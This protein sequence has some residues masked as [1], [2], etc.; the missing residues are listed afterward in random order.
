MNECK[1]KD[2]T[3]DTRPKSPFCSGTCKK[4]YQRASGTDVPV[5]VGQEPS[6]TQFA[7]PVVLDRPITQAD[8]NVAAEIFKENSPDTILARQPDT[9]LLPPGVAKPTGQRTLGAADMTSPVLSRRISSYQ[10]ADW[11]A[12][13]E[14]AEVVYRLLTL[15]LDQLADQGQSIPI[16]RYSQGESASTQGVTRQEVT[17]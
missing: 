12:S 13:P 1:W 5:E 17:A 3:N 10:G 2:C 7:V 15:T 9:D 14:Y 6:G 8:I 11:I 4:R 16:W